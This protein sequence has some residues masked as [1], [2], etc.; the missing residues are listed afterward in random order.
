MLVLA[1]IVPRMSKGINVSSV[2]MLLNV[3]VIL[4]STI[5]RFVYLNDCVIFREDGSPFEDIF[6]KIFLED[7]S[8]FCGATDTLVLDFW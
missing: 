3:K 4:S 2:S 7:I 1:R 8:N 6:S 5:R